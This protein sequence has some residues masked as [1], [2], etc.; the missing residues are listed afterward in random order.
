MQAATPLEGAL[1]RDRAI[2]LAGIVGV[3][4][5]AWAYMFYLAW[6]MQRT[7]SAG[8]MQMGMEMAMSQV[9][10]LGSGGFPAHVRHVGGND[11]CHDGPAGAFGQICAAAHIDSNAPAGPLKP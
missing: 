2:V 11:D 7:M 6:D 3:T 5:L 8:S 4:A 1:R 10:G 9:R